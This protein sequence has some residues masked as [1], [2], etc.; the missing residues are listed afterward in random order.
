MTRHLW[1][2]TLPLLLLAC[3][4]A[5]DSGW[6]G[7]AEGEHVYVAAPIGGRLD[8]LSVR[9]GERVRQGMPLFAL[10]AQAEL[11]ASAEAKARLQAS[12]AQADNTAKGRRPDELAVTRAQ[13]AQAQAQ[14]VLAQAAWRREKELVDKGFV[15]MAQLDSAAAT[16]RQ[17]EARVAELDSALRVASLPARSDERSAALAQVESARQAWQQAEWRVDQKQ[18]RAPVDAE[19]AEVFFRPGEFVAAGQPVLALLPADAVKARFYVPE[20]EL[21]SVSLGQP[22]R[23]SCDGCG[24]PV[25]ARV[26]RIATAPEFTP[27]VIYSNAQR[28]R[29]VYLVE[30]QPEAGAAVSMRPGQPLDV[31][32]LPK[33]TP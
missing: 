25:T 17:S 24:A 13:R 19:V 16:L 23:L 4:P 22:V 20:N 3:S 5:P 15:S 33:G 14:A 31:T 21:T 10:D 11:A 32:P 1:S 8:Q 29:L 27:P 6:S 9:A 2:A 28:A 26:S 18:Q 12:Q 30:A 7:Y